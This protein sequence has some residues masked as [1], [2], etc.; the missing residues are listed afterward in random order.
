MPTPMRGVIAGLVTV[1]VVLAT[2]CSHGQRS[3]VSPA[4]A[5]QAI[6]R[7]ANEWS[8]RGMIVDLSCQSDPSDST[9]ASCDG[10]PVECRGPAPFERWFVH[11]SA[12]GRLVVSDP[13]P[14]SDVYCIV[15]VKPGDGA[16]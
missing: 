6:E 7:R 4:A 15:N 11:V 2:G 8:R 13:Q 1:A 3:G 16:G 14:N 12:A 10:S 5:K 9:A